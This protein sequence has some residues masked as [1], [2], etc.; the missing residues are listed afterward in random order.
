M[1]KV[2]PAH[3]PEQVEAAR[4]L[5]E[6]KGYAKKTVQN[7][8]GVWHHLLKYADSKSITVCTGELITKFARF[9]YGIEDIFH[10]TTDRE[11]YY[12][13]ILLCL[14]DLSTEDLWI[15]H[16]T[17]R[18]VRQFQ[19]KSFAAAYNS[20]TTW[21][22]GK[23]LKQGSISLKQQIIRDFLYFAEGEQISDIS[24]LSQATILKYLESKSGFSTSTKSGII[25]TLRD[26]FKCPEVAGMLEKDLSVNLKVVNNGKYEHLPSTYSIDEI[27]RILAVIDRKTSEGKKDYAVILL[28]VDTGLRIS[29]IINLRLGDLKW[30]CDT[31]EIIQQK[32][33]EFLQLSMTDALKWALIDYLMNARPKGTAFDHVFLRSLAP[34]SPYMSAGRYYNRLNKYFELAGVNRDGKHH[35]M[36]TLRH[37][38]ATRLMGDNVPITVISEA[39]GHKYANVTMRYVRID[40][41]KLRLAALGV[42]SNG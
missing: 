8:S 7:Y 30:D 22:G 24:E 20:Y 35:G 11:K 37:S 34:V 12:A 5:M 42:P 28:A 25:I 26:F 27:K 41:E 18:L 6:E 21:L 19:T 33:G 29:D 14:Y 40:I 38:L 39:L 36:H 23:T 1:Y 9:R 4:K 31:I 10:P 17:Y 15:T 13:R 3:L 32:T 2:F 16:R